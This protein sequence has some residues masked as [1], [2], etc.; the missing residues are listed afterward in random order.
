MPVGIIDKVVAKATRLKIICFSQRI[1]MPLT[2]A[3]L[4][5]I[6][7]LTP[8]NLKVTD[9]QD[10]F[11]RGVTNIMCLVLSTISWK[12]L[13]EGCFSGL[14]LEHIN[15]LEY[16]HSNVLKPLVSLQSFTFQRVV[17]SRGA[18]SYGDNSQILGGITSSSFHTLVLYAIHSV[19]HSE[20]QL[21]INDLFVNRTC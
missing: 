10:N 21:D 12:R 2:F 11:F 3:N 16:L 17:S 15:Q 4:F 13:E 14:S 5:N 8:V 20:T 9:S 18:M 6:R 19:L 7:E 1:L